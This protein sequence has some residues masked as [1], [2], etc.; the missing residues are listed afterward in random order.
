MLRP[1]GHSTVTCS[2]SLSLSIRLSAV[3]AF[4][5]LNPLSASGHCQEG[6]LGGALQKARPALVDPAVAGRGTSAYSWRWPSSPRLLY[7][8]VLVR[9][10]NGYSVLF[11]WYMALMEPRNSGTKTLCKR[12]SPGKQEIMIFIDN[13]VSLFISGYPS[14]IL[15]K[16]PQGFL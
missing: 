3:P 16:T 13:V 11:A 5:S 2:L 12:L 8:Y 14:K 9:G 6:R 15:G 1:G 4:L 7:V 10:S